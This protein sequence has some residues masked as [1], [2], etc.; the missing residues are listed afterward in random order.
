MDI[1]LIQGE[2]STAETIDIVAQM[3][4]VKIR[5]HECAIA[6]NSSEEDIEYRESKIRTLQRELH[7]LKQ[8]YTLPNQR[9]TMEA[10]IS[11]S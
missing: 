1:Q 3:V 10:T 6:S 9:L 8:Q 2:F 5:F 7:E 4:Q 11:L